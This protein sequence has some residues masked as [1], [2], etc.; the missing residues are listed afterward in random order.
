MAVIRDPSLP[1]Q[2]VLLVISGSQKIVL[3]CN[4]L[5]AR[6]PGGGAPSYGVIEERT[7]WKDSREAEV[8]YRNFHLRAAKTEPAM[9]VAS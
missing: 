8:I 7:C 6:P 3:S 4:C 1:H 5:A 9:A 2:L